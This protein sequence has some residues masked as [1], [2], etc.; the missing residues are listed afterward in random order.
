MEGEEGIER[1]DGGVRQA[2]LPGGGLRSPREIVLPA[3]VEETVIIEQWLRQKKGTK[4]TL[5]VPE[6]GE[7]KQLL[8]MASQNAKLALEQMQATSAAEHDRT[9]GRPD[10][11]AG[12]ARSG[13]AAG[14]H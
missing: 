4:V 11:I 13:L 5:T 8:D 10:G 9:R 7:K 14:A 3:H 1:R 6:R 12:R 2:V